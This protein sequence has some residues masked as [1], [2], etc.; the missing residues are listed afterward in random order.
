MLLVDLAHG[1]E[2]AHTEGFKK[3]ISGQIAALDHLTA[4]AIRGFVPKGILIEASSSI[5][6]VDPNMPFNV[7][8][9]GIIRLAE[10]ARSR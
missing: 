8:I 2:M 4:L 1:S 6:P 9:N 5:S 3:S 7:A 10:I